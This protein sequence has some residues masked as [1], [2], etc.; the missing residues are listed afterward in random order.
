MTKTHILPGEKAAR[1]GVFAL[2]AV[3]PLFITDVY[4]NITATKYIYFSIVAAFFLMLCL[5]GKIKAYD[6]TT[7]KSTVKLQDLPMPDLFFLLFVLVALVSTVSSRFKLASLGGGGGRRMGL[8]MILACFFAYVMISKFYRIR[9]KELFFFGTTII[10]SSL[11]G[12]AQFLGFDPLYMLANLSSF[13]S[14]RFISFSGNINVHASLMCIGAPFA[15][16]IFCFAENKKSRI[17][18]LLVSICGFIGFLTCNSDSGYLGMVA[19]FAAL[20]V[21]SAKTKESFVRYLRLVAVFFVTCMA[22]LGVQKLFEETSRHITFLGRIVT[23][24]ALGAAVAVVALLL[25]FLIDKKVSE[26]KTIIKIRKLIIAAIISVIAIV[27]FIVFWF[28]VIDKTTDLGIFNFYLRFNDSW[29]TERGYV[30]TRMLRIFGNFPLNKKL[31]GSGPDTAAFELLSQYG[32][33]MRHE[34]FYYFDNAHN[35]IIQYLVTL[36]LLGTG[37][38][39][40]L[41][42]TSVKTAL[43]SVSVYSRAAVLPIIAFFAQSVV[44]IYQPITTPLFFVFIALSQCKK[45]EDANI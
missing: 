41:I 43:G 27:A 35:D 30:W 14:L 12:F 32:Y 18:W 9:G 6:F 23:Y 22:F 44:N 16:Y 40:A 31:I 25:S 19:A 37:T 5:I 20:A 2:T 42:A 24:P 15:M 26:P 8:I 29:G 33:E 11:F 34:L 36:G 10:I 3:F 28:S 4:N 38:Y 17:F 21:L 1:I 7:V 13:D 39:I 45:Y